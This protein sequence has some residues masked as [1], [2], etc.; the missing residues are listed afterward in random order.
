[1]KRI[2]LVLS[3]VLGVFSFSYSKETNQRIEKQYSL[4]NIKNFKVFSKNADIKV[5]PTD[6]KEVTMVV[7]T[8][9]RKVV[10]KKEVK[11]GELVVSVTPVKK[12]S[13]SFSFKNGGVNILL[14]IPKNYNDK[15][16]LAS[17]NGDIKVNNL[18]I[19][20]KA[21]TKNGAILVKKVVGDSAIDTKNGKINVEN[22]QGILKAETK[23]G[24]IRVSD[25]NMIKGLYTKNGE[26]FV[27]RSNL[28]KGGRIESSN[29][30]LDLELLKIEGDNLIA[31]TNGNIDLSVNEGEFKG[32]KITKSKVEDRTKNIIIRSSSNGKVKISEKK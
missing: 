32:D 9:N 31:T 22:L 24:V 2:I 8:K 25:V 17:K 13:F 15:L 21:E 6:S 29:G 12:T 26:V 3:L 23:N 1:M 4:E 7:T 19:E 30:R 18:N 16:Y 20:L 14:N 10:I 27:K 11:D 28:A 5:V